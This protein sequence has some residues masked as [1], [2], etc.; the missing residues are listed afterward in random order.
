MDRGEITVEVSRITFCLRSEQCSWAKKKYARI[1]R[2]PSQTFSALAVP[3]GYSKCLEK[4]TLVLA[5]DFMEISISFLEDELFADKRHEQKDQI[6]KGR[7]LLVGHLVHRI[8]E[9]KIVH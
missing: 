2:K 6:E 5:H 1:I 3:H 7:H 8:D 9:P 4:V